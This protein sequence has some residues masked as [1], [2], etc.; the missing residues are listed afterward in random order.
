MTHEFQD[1]LLNNSKV[2]LL[3]YTGFQKNKSS[4][5]NTIA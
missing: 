1:I 3:F 2:V 4:I 5:D